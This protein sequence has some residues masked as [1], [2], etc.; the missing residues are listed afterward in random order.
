M[1]K[2]DIITGQSIPFWYTM[3]PNIQQNKYFKESILKIR[4]SNPRNYDLMKK[5]Q[6]GIQVID[7]T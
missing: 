2:K 6:D 5:I 3:Y 4:K 1:L 7:Y